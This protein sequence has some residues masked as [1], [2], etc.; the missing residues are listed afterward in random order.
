VKIL[1]PK[2]KSETRKRATSGSINLVFRLNQRYYDKPTDTTLLPFME[3]LSQFLDCN[4]LSFDDNKLL[5][6]SLTS[7]EKLTKLIIYFNKYPL[8][9]IKGRDFND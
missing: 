9:G 2:P 5:Y 3:R 1:D 4:V 7:L 6:V 8:L